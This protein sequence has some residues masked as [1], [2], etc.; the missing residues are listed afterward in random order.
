MG[1]CFSYKVT[2]LEI[3]DEI[4]STVVLDIEPLS[5]DIC[6]LTLKFPNVTVTGEAEK[7]LCTV[8]T[9]REIPVKVETYCCDTPYCDKSRKNK[10]W[11][12]N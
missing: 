10:I 6:L 3:S 9:G 11:F 1:K 8:E 2:R 7:E 12:T 5:T 4:H